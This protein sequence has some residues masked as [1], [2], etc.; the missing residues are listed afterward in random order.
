MCSLPLEHESATGVNS[1]NAMA[2]DFV[3]VVCYCCIKKNNNWIHPSSFTLNLLK[4]GC[5][6]G[7]SCSIATTKYSCS[8]SVG[9]KQCFTSSF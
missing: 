6:W 2:F 4:Q 5:V 7:A 3:F 9:H 1:A 8:L